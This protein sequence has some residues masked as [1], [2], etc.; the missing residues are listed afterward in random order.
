MSRVRNIADHGQSIWLDY[1]DRNL[2]DG[3]GLKRLV[4]ED[5]VVGVTSNP[6]IFQKAIAG[7]EDYSAA[8]D[9]LAPSCADA[10]ALY[11]AVAIRDIQDAAD[12][13]ASVY[14]SSSARDG[15][16]SLE[17]SPNLA[18]DTQGTIDE[19]RRLWA[20]V[21]RPNLMVK[22][23]GTP[24]GMPA[25]QTLITDGIN[26]NVTLLF[27]RAMYERTAEAFIAGLEARLSVGKSIEGIAS[28]ASF[29]ISRIDSS[30]DKRLSE[31]GADRSLAG[32]VAI[33]NAQLAYVH[34]E[35]LMAGARW[36]PLAEAGAM[37]QR[38][39]WASTSTKDP[40]YRD[41][42]YIEALIGAD[43][44]NTVPPTTLDAF[45][46]HGEA[47]NTLAGTAKAAQIQ[48]DAVLATGL[49]L[50]GITDT[51]L[52]DGITIFA[53]AFVELLAVVEA[54]R[55]SHTQ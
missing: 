39:L 51:L 8:M 37:P 24:E 45:R 44:V 20:A 6:A 54:A 23:P 5:A 41:V 22:V 19:A 35:L 7:G 28:V 2:L 25:I 16:V 21:D 3:G 50:D 55:V 17:V 27:A 10:K 15:Y 48:M 14:E 34:Y 1:I 42:L 29:F 4:E 18:R 43:T 13:L 40:S 12:I 47:A 11:E 33:A 49:D 53:D 9:E 46:D 38:L 30:V 32:K 52:E 36:A 26:V 31:L